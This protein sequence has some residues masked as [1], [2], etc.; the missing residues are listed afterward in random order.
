MVDEQDRHDDGSGIRRTGRGADEGDGAKRGTGAPGTM[1]DCDGAEGYVFTESQKASIAALAAAEDYGGQS[2]WT[3]F[4]QLPNED[5]WPYFRQ[6][7]LLGV[8]IVLIVVAVFGSLGITYLTKPPEPVL[9]VY[10]FGI[11][12]RQSQFESL[13][14]GFADYAKLDDDRLVDFD[15]AMTLDGSDYQND[16]AKVMVM[17]AAGTINMVIAD[18]DDFAKL[19]AQGYVSSLSEGLG[20]KR[21]AELSDAMVEA[22]G[23]PAT[24][25]GDAKGLD[26]SK[27]RTW[28]SIKGL[29]DDA[30]LGFSNVENGTDYPRQFVDYLDFR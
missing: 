29:P 23:D 21:A 8:V 7:F 5:K 6:H 1:K 17:V 3:T 11:E 18:P 27:S 15:S 20:A 4:R 28:T 13:G 22:D 19:D 14:Q 26:L 2:K 9:A 16:S 25:V 24:D 10:G 12:D 30:I